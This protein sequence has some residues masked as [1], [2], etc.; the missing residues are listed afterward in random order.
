[1]QMTSLPMDAMQEFRVVANNYAAEFGHSA[2]GVITLTTRSGTNQL[3]GSV[4][5]FPA[6]ARSTPATS[7]PAPARRSGWNQYGFS[8]SAGPSVAIRL[9]FVSWERTKSR[10]RASPASDSAV[11]RA[12]SR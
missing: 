3:H 8:R 2:G 12:A 5:E 9:T 1:M 4:F 10:D 7:S 11:A 6:T